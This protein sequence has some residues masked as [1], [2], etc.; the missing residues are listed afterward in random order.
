[1]KEIPK[2]DKNEMAN[3]IEEINTNEKIGVNNKNLEVFETT[4]LALDLNKDN[5][6]NWYLDSRSSTHV[7]RD[8]SHFNKLKTNVNPNIFK[9]IGGHTHVICGKGDITLSHN[10]LIRLVHDILYVPNITK[11]L[12]F[13]GVI[14]DK[15]CMVIFGQKIVGLLHPPNLPKNHSNRSKRS[16]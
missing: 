15:G 8:S 3:T 4:M 6:T 13:V 5:D 10:G 16:C 7:T 1:M 14:T 12:L 11:N 9:F 2:F